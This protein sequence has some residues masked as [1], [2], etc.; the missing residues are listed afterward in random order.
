MAQACTET[1]RGHL[2]VADGAAHSDRRQADPLGRGLCQLTLQAVEKESGEYGALVAYYFG[3]KQ[4][5][6]D[7]LFKDLMQSRTRPCAKRLDENRVAGL[8]RARTHR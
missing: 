7:A 2:V 5:L 8:T 6:I 1:G 3:N 4:G